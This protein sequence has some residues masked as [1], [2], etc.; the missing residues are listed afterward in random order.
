MLK[1]EEGRIIGRKC[2]APVAPNV[3]DPLRLKTLFTIQFSQDQ[4]DV[5]IFCHTGFSE[6][7]K[8]CLQWVIQV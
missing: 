5:E 7:H 8:G 6:P 2:I 4:E 3:L 1:F